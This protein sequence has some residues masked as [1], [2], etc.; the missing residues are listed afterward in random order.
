[1]ESPGWHVSLLFQSGSWELPPWWGDKVDLESQG[2]K[3]YHTAAQF[4]EAAGTTVAKRLKSCVLHPLLLPRSLVLPALPQHSKRAKVMSAN[5][6]SAFLFLLRVWGMGPELRAQLP[7][8]GTQ[9][10]KHN[11]CHFPGSISPIHSIHP[12]SDVQTCGSLRHSSVL[13]KGIY[14]EF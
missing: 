1:M 13:R 7:W 12:L 11:P 6:A 4:P 14:V 10:H 2:C 5:A 3:P 9:G 8:L